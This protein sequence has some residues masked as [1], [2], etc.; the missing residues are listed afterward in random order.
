MRERDRNRRAHSCHFYF[1][2]DVEHITLAKMTDVSTVVASAAAPAAAAVVEDL[3]L[4]GRLKSHFSA[5]PPHLKGANVCQLLSTVVQKGEKLVSLYVPKANGKPGTVAI[6][7]SHFS[8]LEALLVYVS[9][10]VGFSDEDKK[11]IVCA[12]TAGGSVDKTRVRKLKDL[13]E[14]LEGHVN[15]ESVASEAFTEA[16]KV[17]EYIDAKAVGQKRKASESVAVAADAVVASDA[18]TAEKPKRQKTKK[19]PAAVEES[20]AAAMDVAVAAVEKEKKPRKPRAKK[21]D[22]PA[23]AGASAVTADVVEKA[24]AGAAPDNFLNDL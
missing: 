10:L 2:R 7:G 16:K 1:A 4:A 17:F 22:S 6:A 15:L 21:A 11:Q 20:G 3:S 8:S 14:K 24:L 19:A 18:A 5:L 23:A 9:K 12:S 13:V